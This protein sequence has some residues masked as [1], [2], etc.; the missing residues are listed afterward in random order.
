[1]KKRTVHIW[2]VPGG[3]EFTALAV[4]SVAFSLGAFIGIVTAANV[5]GSG[6]DSLTTY[7][8]NYFAAAKAGASA[9]P[10]LL[11]SFWDTVRW[12]LL[13]FLMGVTALGVV[14]IPALFSIRGFLLSFSISSFVRMFGGAGSILA[15]FSFGL[16]GMLAIPSLFVLGVQGFASASEL[17]IRALG[18]G[19]GPFPFGKI[20]WIRCSLCVVALGL[21][22]ILEYWAV[23]A[24]LYSVADLFLP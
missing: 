13:A 6:Q 24:L 23:P 20:Y 17:A 4:I 2:D 8:E 1:M 12:P 3:N 7:I 19:K 16:T 11:V 15:F 9:P 21:C 10:G 22:A 5:G 18:A 14:G